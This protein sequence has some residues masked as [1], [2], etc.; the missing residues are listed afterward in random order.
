MTEEIEF[1]VPVRPYSPIDAHNRAAAAKGHHVTEAFNSY[2][3]YWTAEY[4]WAGRVVL[5][6]GSFAD[7]L[8]AAL[9]EHARGAL[10]ASVSVRIPEGDCEAL[11][12]AKASPSLV[13]GSLWVECSYG[14]REPRKDSWWTWRHDVGHESAKDM[15]NP[16]ALTLIFDWPLCQAS[17]SREAY[18]A[19]VMT[20][21]G[22]VYH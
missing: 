7:C 16:G 10:G 20:K 14:M 19:A 9:S 11:E 3:K 15:S 22:R 18:K 13:A 21:Y 8:A 12:A 6:R 17:D 4:F 5:R 2:R 1:H